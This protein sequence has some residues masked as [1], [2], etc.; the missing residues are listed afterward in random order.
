MNSTKRFIFGLVSSLLLTA[1]FVRAANS[2]DPI[3]VS[4]IRGDSN[5]SL[6]AATENCVLPCEVNDP[7]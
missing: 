7:K 2:L 4:Q 5:G 1:G 3:T 6:T